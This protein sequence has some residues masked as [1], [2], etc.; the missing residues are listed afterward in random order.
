M[1]S[2]GSATPPLVVVQ[3]I[4]FPRPRRRRSRLFA[5]GLRP[6]LPR[7]RP[8]FLEPDLSGERSADSDK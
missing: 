8:H 6:A 2:E 5:G 3:A 1:G 4:F 7:L